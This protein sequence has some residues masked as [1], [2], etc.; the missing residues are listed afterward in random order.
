[1]EMIFIYLLSTCEEK[2][3]GGPVSSDQFVDCIDLTA[4]GEDSDEEEDKDQPRC[5]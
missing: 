5:V 3:N 2:D 4:S 1:M